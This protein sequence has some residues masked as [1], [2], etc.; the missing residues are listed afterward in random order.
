MI[1]PGENLLT[2]PAK[3]AESTMPGSRGRVL[4]ACYTFA[5]AINGM[6]TVMGQ[7]VEGFRRLGYDVEVVTSPHPARMTPPDGVAVTEFAITGN[8][9]LGSPF[10]GE[11]REY[12]EFLL[13]YD[14][15]VVVFH[16]WESWP[17]EL[18]VPVARRMK[19][20]T[21]M[22]SHGTSYH[23]RPPS[24]WGWLRWLS[25]RPYV[26][27]AERK[28]RVFDEYVFL[29]DT[30]EPVRF[31]DRRLAERLGLTN[32]RVIPNG[33]NP[34]Y[35]EAEGGVGEEFR[36]RHGIRTNR[37]LLC[38]SNYGLAKGQRDLL[39]AFLGTDSPDTSLVL[40]G[41]EMNA[42]GE[43]LRQQAGQTLGE[44]VFV[45]V[46]LSPDEVRAAYR[47]ADLFVTATHTEAQ[48]L[49]LLDAMAAG[50]P[51]VATPVGCIA[52]L[53]GGQMFRTKSEFSTVVKTLLADE[54][55]RRRLGEAGREAVRSRYNWETAVGAYHRLFDALKITPRAT[56]P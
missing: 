22:A 53:P 2:P 17:S 19:A 45:L 38:V 37:V 51:F 12:Q 20:R 26:R 42:F 48:P 49:M 31:D 47:A 11:T 15:D 24:L 7:Q 41:S 54:A 13:A 40:I 56:T 35:L 50:L 27:H 46:G 39:D 33:A 18:A 36:R 5:P 34:A 52:E 3:P 30:A 10:R 16:G 1:F 14:G 23:W 29:T 8:G 25:Y 28:L 55:Q 6:A 43:A 32:W 21:V 44:R 4:L 9:R